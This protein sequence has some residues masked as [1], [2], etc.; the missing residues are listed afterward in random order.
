M[1]SFGGLTTN[2]EGGGR[3]LLRKFSTSGLP[4][5]RVSAKTVPRLAPPLAVTGSSQWKV[6]AWQMHKRI[7]A[8]SGLSAILRTP[9]RLPG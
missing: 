2:F 1:A 5:S 4:W 3:F 7:L 8:E 9:S 6:S